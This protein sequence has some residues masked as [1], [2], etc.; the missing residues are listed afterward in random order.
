ME[1][2]HTK[3]FS[4]EEARKA[5]KSASAI[6][7]ELAELKRILDEKGYDVYRHQYFGGTGPNGERVFPVELE[8]IVE[9]LKKLES[10]GIL[11]K[12]LEE[13]L[14]D[15]PFIRSNNQEVYLC[16]KLGESDI[17]Y[18]HT[19]ADGFAGRTPIEKL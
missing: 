2:L 5:V 15:F 1:Y 10:E 8:K 9:L 19:I 6:L 17:R 14:I 18:W 12:N 11:V 16:W 7:E 13:G 4:L 3:H